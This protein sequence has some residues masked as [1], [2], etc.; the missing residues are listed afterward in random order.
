MGLGFGLVGAAL[1]MAISGREKPPASAFPVHTGVLKA[2]PPQPPVAVPPPPP[3]ISESP[4]AESVSA[5]AASMPSQ[6]PTTLTNSSTI[7]GEEQGDGVRMQAYTKAASSLAHELRGPLLSLLGRARLLREKTGDTDT[8]NELLRIE[9]G[10]REAHGTL[11]KLLTF[12]GEKE[13]PTVPTALSEVITR[14][15]RKLEDEFLKAGISAEAHLADV[16]LI[17]GQPNLLSKAFDQILENS[18]EAMNKAAKKKLT[19]ILDETTRGPRLIIEDTGE[20]IEEAL[21]NQI[22]D[23]F[24]TTKS[25]N[26]SGL[27][28]SLALGI[29]KACTGEVQVTSTRGQGTRIEVQFDL[30]AEKTQKPVRI[31]AATSD[32]EGMHEEDFV[33]RGPGRSRR[34]SQSAAPVARDKDGFPTSVL[35]S[36]NPAAATR[37]PPH[38]E[39]VV[40]S[41]HEGP[42]VLNDQLMEK[43]LNMIDHLD[44]VAEPKNMTPPAAPPPRHAGGPAIVVES[45]PPPPP[46]IANAS[47]AEPPPPPPQTPA[48]K[49]SEKI[50]KPKIGFKKKDSRTLE[51]NVEVRRPGDRS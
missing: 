39:F 22:F 21:L 26:H 12:S 43:T 24:F 49:V 8:R 47:P 1:I 28:L 17:Q 41:A 30:Q 40:N 3:L 37:P 27:G 46:P 6:P 5:D 45:A 14:S 15:L 7:T 19:V 35:T 16:H 48:E 10:A 42:S 13:E 25:A 36:P 18:I 29:I 20:G 44:E 38:P 51:T 34:P 23:P 11:H 32:F 2:P 50:D 33:M 4:G 31:E 9:E